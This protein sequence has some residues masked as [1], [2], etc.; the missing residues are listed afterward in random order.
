MPDRNV[1]RLPK[2]RHYKPKNLGVV[3]ID[4]KDHCLGHYGSP[5]SQEAYRR[6]LAEWLAGR[7]GGLPSQLQQPGTD[8]GLIVN[9]L[10]LAYVRFSD[11]YY[12][13]NGRRTVEPTNSRLALRLVRR[14]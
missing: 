7:G 5:E 10:I 11:R 6:L 3:R 12:V 2:Y 9:E 8:T 13:K 1:S 14:L 4:G